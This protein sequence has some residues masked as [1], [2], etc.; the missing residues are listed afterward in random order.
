MANEIYQM[1][2]SLDFIRPEIWRSF[3]VDSSIL[4]DDFH[5]IIQ[6]IMGWTNT[7][8]YGFNIKNEDYSPIDEDSD[9]SEK[10]SKIFSLRQL[11]LQ[12][13]DQIRYTYDFGDDWQHTIIL[14]K[15][16]QPDNKMQTPYCLDGARN[17]PPEDCGST[18]G[19]EGIVEAMKTP[20]SKAAKEFIEWLGEPY[21]PEKFNK[22][23]INEILTPAKKKARKRA[24]G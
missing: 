7:H 18:P 13:K 15:V 6:N 2:I 20:K 4:L 9:P 21:D 19:Y 14:E 16:L 3:V 12:E 22:D 8:L 23:E 17:C 5:N 10:D 1:K 24:G 11:E